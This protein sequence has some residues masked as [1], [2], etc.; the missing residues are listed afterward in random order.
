MSF[1]PIAMHWSQNYASVPSFLPAEGSPYSP[2]M[3]ILVPSGKFRRRWCICGDIDVLAPCRRRGASAVL[4]HA[5]YENEKYFLVVSFS[6]MLHSYASLQSF[7]FRINIVDH[8]AA[9]I[10][11]FCTD[12]P[13][14]LFGV[15][16]WFSEHSADTADQTLGCSCESCAWTFKSSHALNMQ[17]TKRNEA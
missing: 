15:W 16:V 7:P 17:T 9:E 10:V 14:L 2:G 6:T 13:Q 8:W 4:S 5:S 11:Y 12:R 1:L 3:M